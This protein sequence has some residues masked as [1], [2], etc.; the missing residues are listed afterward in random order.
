MG[1]STTQG[2]K[3]LHYSS[4]AVHGNLKSTNCAIDMRWVLKVTDFGVKNIY[5]KT[6]NKLKLE[7][8]GEL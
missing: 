2:M 4:L 1:R 7:T 8:K 6:K 5:D 3:Y